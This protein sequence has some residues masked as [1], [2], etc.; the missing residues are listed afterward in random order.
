MVSVLSAIVSGVCECVRY[1]RCGSCENPTCR[2]VYPEF[3]MGDPRV[4]SGLPDRK[5]LSTAAQPG[6]GVDSRLDRLV[7]V[8]HGAFHRPFGS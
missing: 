2:R 8:E 3:R 1:C 4:T 6:V 7:H 5:K